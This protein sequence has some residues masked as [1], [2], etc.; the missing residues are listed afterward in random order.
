MKQRML[1][2]EAKIGILIV[3]STNSEMD[4]RATMRER[5][6]VLATKTEQALRVHFRSHNGG[7]L[8]ASAVAL[9]FSAA[10]WALLYGA[11]YWVT[12]IVVTLGQNG[13][14]PVPAVFNTVFI[15]TA[16][17]LLAAARV[18]QWFF[19]HERAVDE[20]PPVEHFADLIFFVPRFTMS[21][22]QNLGALALLADAEF[23]D[24]A[25]LM[26]RLKGEGRV[27]VQALPAMF[28]GGRRTGRVLNALLLTCL[29]D[30]RKAEGEIWLYIGALA[31]DVFRSKTG[32]L[33]APE[34]PL[35]G[36]PQVK[37]RRRV[38]L[39]PPREDDE[40]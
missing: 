25:R 26:D 29:V 4:V 14:V 21:C 13:A 28:C 34:D 18:D 5:A 23:A 32:A 22:W 20:R 2:P 6:P 40:K 16:L 9:V 30:Q 27:S 35:A 3:K 19:P 37:I 24:A 1:L 12:M 33:P 17:V 39:L 38:R 8:A 36:V 10:G 31:P 7:V 11:S 15:E